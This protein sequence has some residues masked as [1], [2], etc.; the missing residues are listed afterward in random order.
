[1]SRT[2]VV[3]ATGNIGR[4][5]TAHHRACVRRKVLLDAWSA[6]IGQPAFVTETVAEITGTPARSFLGWAT[7][8]VADFRP[9][10]S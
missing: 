3:G 9:P 6:A 1:M 5:G 2:L 4:K 7:D 10:S 8:H